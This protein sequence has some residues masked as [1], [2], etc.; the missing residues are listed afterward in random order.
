MYT[1]NIKAYYILVKNKNF[2]REASLENIFLK[3]Y[4]KKFITTANDEH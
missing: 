4:R 3:N 1:M 2:K